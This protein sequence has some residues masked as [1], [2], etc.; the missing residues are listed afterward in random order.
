MPVKAR[1]YIALVL[2]IGWGVLFKGLVEWHTTD[3][4]GF[5]LYVGVSL[6]ASGYKLR[7][8]GITATVSACFLL[9]LIGIIC[10]SLP[11]AVV[12]GCAAVAFQCVWH[13]TSRPRPIKIAFSVASVAI[14]ITVSA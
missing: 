14:A 5:V 8:P 2:L 3:W 4:A 6:L 11:E 13:S 7:L 10:L 12:G 9:M 1:A